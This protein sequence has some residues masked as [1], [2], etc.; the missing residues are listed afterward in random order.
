MITRFL[1]VERLVVENDDDEALSVYVEDDPTMVAKN[2]AED[3]GIE[4]YHIHLNPGT[5][6]ASIRSVNLK[7]GPRAAGRGREIAEVEVGGVVIGSA[8]VD[9]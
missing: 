9:A 5:L 3:R 6:L 8:E 1:A 7:G 2:L 4:Y